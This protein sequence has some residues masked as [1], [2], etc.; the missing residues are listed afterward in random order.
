MQGTR[1]YRN[2]KQMN[3]IQSGVREGFKEEVIVGGNQVI[4]QKERG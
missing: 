2:I 4:I 3:L 1:S